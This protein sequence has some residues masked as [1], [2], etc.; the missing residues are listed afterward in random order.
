M[1]LYCEDCGRPQRYL[2]GWESTQGTLIWPDG[3]ETGYVM[4][5]SRCWNI[6]DSNALR[7]K[8]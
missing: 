1:K 7:G 5:C 4:L 3:A 2:L 6:R 8:P